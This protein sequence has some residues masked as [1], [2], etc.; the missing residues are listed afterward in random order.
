M[1]HWKRLSLAIGPGLR[2]SCAPTPFQGVHVPLR[3]PSPAGRNIESG[4]GRAHRGR[5]VRLDVPEPGSDHSRL[6]VTA[7]ADLEPDHA[8]AA[9][10]T[11]G[12]SDARIAEAHFTDDAFS[13]LSRPDVDVAVEATG[14][15]EA[16]IRHARGAFAAGKHV[17]MVNVEADVLAGPLLALEAER[18]GVVYTMAYGDQPALTCELVEWARCSGFDV[19]AAGKGTKYLPSYHAS[20]PD[21]VWEHYASPRSKRGRR[22]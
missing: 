14:R 4:A 16:G 5:Q 10:R 7:I 17:V 21:T 2:Q 20:T 15:P 19:A 11:A 13:L 9:C 12:W 3:G 18:T 8:R 1:C 6:K 22:G